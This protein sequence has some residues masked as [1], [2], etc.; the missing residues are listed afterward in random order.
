MCVTHYQTQSGNI[1]DE[2]FSVVLK[3]IIPGSILE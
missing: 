2:V 3:V 1:D